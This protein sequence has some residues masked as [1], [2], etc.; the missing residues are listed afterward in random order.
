MSGKRWRVS[1]FLWAVAATC[2]VALSAA[3]EEF[4]RFESRVPMLRAEI[5]TLNLL[6]GLYLTGDQMTTLLAIA[7]RANAERDRARIENAPLQREMEQAFLEL[8]SYVL[9]GKAIPED[10]KVRAQE[11]NEQ[12]KVALEDVQ[13]KLKELESE[14]ELILTDSQKKVVEDF[15]PCLV[16]PKSLG[17]PSRAGQARDP[18]R[19][20]AAL[21]RIRQIPPRRLEFAMARILAK[22]FEALDKHMPGTLTPEE[23]QAEEQRIVALIRK[24]RAMTDEE[25][26]LNKADLGNEL[27]RTLDRRD[28][29]VK[30]FQARFRETES[31]GKIGRFLAT[32][33]IV[34]LLEERIKLAKTFS[35][36]QRR[37][38]PEL[39]EAAQ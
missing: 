33:E 6:N 34:P 23:R 17:N 19:G 1:V 26:A 35:P 24:A 22:H 32:P 11:L 9:K 14:V 30:E 4:G 2:A 20:E 18:A 12:G 27:T 29:E 28:A 7:R 10:V 8:R 36:R 16:P 5:S 31:L 3:T 25:F 38:L 39:P 21:E 15:K 37:G 13:R